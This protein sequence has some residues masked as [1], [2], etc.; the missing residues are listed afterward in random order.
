MKKDRD[1]IL[2]PFVVGSV[3][4]LVR[5]GATIT[6]ECVEP[7]T[8][9]GS[10]WTGNWRVFAMQDGI[11]YVLVAQRTILPR[12]HKS[13]NAILSFAESVGLRT[14]ALPMDA[15]KFAAFT[16]KD[17]DFSKATVASETKP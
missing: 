6:I 3:P 17:F 15:G 1:L 5:D 4:E 2:P 11:K 7:P 12:D 14:P 16:E 10:T 8:R 9:K 13:A